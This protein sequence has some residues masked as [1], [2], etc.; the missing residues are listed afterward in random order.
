MRGPR[1]LTLDDVP[2]E[3]VAGILGAESYRCATPN[4]LLLPVANIRAPVRKLNR[5]AL[6][7]IIAGVRAN[8]S[9]E[10]IRV[11]LLDSAMVDLL[12]GLHRLRTSIACRFRL[13]PCQLI[14]LEDAREFFRYRG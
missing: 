5:E 6:E 10:P 7:S 8:E 12:D 2:H 9:I 14:S 1:D 3:M 4:S 11:Y 13:I